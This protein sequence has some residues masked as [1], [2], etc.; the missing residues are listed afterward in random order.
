[1]G[2][3]DPFR[4]ME[5]YRQHCQACHRWEDDDVINALRGALSFPEPRARNLYDF[6]MHEDSLIRSSA[7]HVM[8]HGWEGKD[9]DHSQFEIPS[10][11]PWT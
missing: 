2:K 4:G 10:M 9:W 6:I 11:T 3:V 7:P 1:M 5:I 8:D